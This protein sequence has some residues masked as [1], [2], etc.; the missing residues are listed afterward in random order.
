MPGPRSA[1]NASA[2]SR[3]GRH[4][5]RGVLAR[6]ALRRDLVN[7]HG[8]LQRCSRSGTVE[9]E[10]GEAV[11]LWV[12]VLLIVLTV[13]VVDQLFRRYFRQE[14]DRTLGARQRGPQTGWKHPTGEV[15]DEM[16]RDNASNKRSDS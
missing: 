3:P 4:R 12:A 6:R 7:T 16:T 11:E 5:S 2:A 9:D 13:V 15:I 14:G 10:E 8:S 1:R